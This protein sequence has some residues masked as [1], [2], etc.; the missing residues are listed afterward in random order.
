MDPIR[1]VAVLGAGVMGSAIAGHLAGCGLHVLLYDREIDGKKLSSKALKMLP[2]Q[3]PSPIFAKSVLEHVEACSFDSDI[4]RLGEVQWVIEAIIERMDIKKS[5][6]AQI[7][8]HVK[9]G[10]ILSSNTSGLGIGAMADVLP[11]QLRPNFLGTHFF[12]PPR[13]MHLM[14][15][16]PSPYTSDEVL[17]QIRIFSRER[18]GKGVVDALDTPD[19]IANRLGVFGMCDTLRLMEKYNLEPEDVDKLTGKFMG[20][21]KSATFRTADLVGLDT[22]AHV[23]GHLAKV[24]NDDPEQDVF[25]LPQWMLDMIK[26]GKLGNKTKGGF[27]RKSKDADGKRV[28]ETIDRTTGEYRAQKKPKWAFMEQAKTMPFAQS[29]H[30]VAAQKDPVGGFVREI[31]SRMFIYA[32]RMIGPVSKDLQSIDRAM[33][34]G[35]NWEMGPFEI[36]HKLGLEKVMA[37][38][39]AAE[40]KTVDWLQDVTDFYARKDGKPLVY[41]PSKKA[42]VEEDRPAEWIR[43]E[44]LHSDGKVIKE[45]SGA[46]ILDLG[47]GIWCLEAHSKM[48]AIGGDLMSLGM[49]AIDEMERRNDVKGMVLAND[50]ENFS[51]GANLMMVLLSAQE[52]EIDDIDLMI[53]AFQKFNMKMKYASKPIVVAPFGLALGGGCEMTLHGQRAQFSAETYM[54]LVEV[55]VGLLPAGGGCKEMALRAAIGDE[56]GHFNRLKDAFERLAMGKV[57]TSA[58]EAGEFGFLRAEDAISINRDNLLYDAKHTV[59]EMSAKGY[60][61]PVANKVKVLGREALGAFEA[62]LYQMLEG[63]FISEYEQM[64]GGKIAY[65]LSGGEVDPGTMVTEEYL[66]D[67]EREGFLRLCMERK[68]MERMGHML[69]TGKPLRN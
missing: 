62:G 37:W 7:A 48:N 40:L 33:K 28:I 38:E 9:K 15:V 1:H 54:G 49:Y 69:K 35:Y 18:L 67:L 57:A 21:P 68:T 8:P 53:R 16:I 60:S 19:F 50:G 39:E 63:K 14:E 23:A 36:L 27:Y 17:Q 46:S 6:Y 55:G 20:R 41:L 64:L 45:N 12:N 22:F 32:T 4:E 61:A 43:C 51:V 5:L 13:Y 25:N 47:D 26:N 65:V 34:W 30:F 59:L 44:D 29:I 58:M 11:E 3:K 24:L 52:G 42:M 2:K 56:K 10:T 66:L 31:M